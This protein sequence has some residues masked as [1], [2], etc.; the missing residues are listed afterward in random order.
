MGPLRVW[1][2]LLLIIALFV[3]PTTIAAAAAPIISG[4][5]PTSGSVS[6]N[7]QVVI[8]GIN[9]SATS[10]NAAGV[11]VTHGPASSPSSRGGESPPHGPGGAGN[12]NPPPAEAPSHR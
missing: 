11:S 10:A 12:G 4:I 1:T 5:S 7:T 3:A 2:A 6:G 8:T 9:L